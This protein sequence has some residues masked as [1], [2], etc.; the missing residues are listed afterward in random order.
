MSTKIG[1]VTCVVRVVDVT[2]HDTPYGEIMTMTLSMYGIFY[3]Y[4]VYF[5]KKYNIIKE[6]KVDVTGRRW[7]DVTQITSTFPDKS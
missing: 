1:A 4:Y 6:K 7:V 2:S 5:I 3:V